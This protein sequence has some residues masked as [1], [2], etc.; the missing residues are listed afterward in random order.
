MSQARVIE[1]AEKTPK[2][3]LLATLAAHHLAEER[4]REKTATARPTATAPATSNKFTGA[5]D[6]VVVQAAFHACSP[7]ADRAEALTEMRRR[8]FTIGDGVYSKS[9]TRSK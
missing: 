5:A 1:I 2:G 7:N 3:K 4:A 8:G 6:S 9:L